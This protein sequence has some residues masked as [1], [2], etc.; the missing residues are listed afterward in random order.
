MEIHDETYHGDRP[1]ANADEDVLGFKD[2]AIAVADSMHALSS[3]DG[4]VVGIEGEWGAGKSSFINLVTNSMAERARGVE[5]VRFLPWLI[6][7]R[8]GMLDELF[9]EI[10]NAALRIVMP[11]P[12]PTRLGRLWQRISIPARIARRARARRIR[13]L[14]SN[15]SGRVLQTF[16]MVDIAYTG[17]M[18]GSAAQTGKTFVDAWVRA[19]SLASEKGELEQELR[20][21]D[22]KIMVLIDDLDR[23]EPGEVV[24]VLRLVRAVVDFPNVVFVLCYSREVVSKS[25]E[26]ALNVNSGDEF[27][28]KIIQVS[29]PVP[30]PE[31]FDLRRMLKGSIY[32][33]FD[34][35]LNGEDLATLEV[36]RRLDVVIDLEGGYGLS[37][38]RHVVRA[39][40]ALRFY[41]ASIVGCVDIAD[42]VWLQ[43]IR[44]QSHG[45]YMWV[46]HYLSEYAAMSRGARVDEGQ[47]VTDTQRL[48][49]LLEVMR[50][51]AG[52][53][54]TVARLRYLVEILP[55]VKYR[56]SSIGPTDGGEL[57]IYEAGS[58]WSGAQSRRLASP[59][60]YRYY[61]AFSAPQG[62]ITDYEFEDLIEIARRNKGGDSER[63]IKLARR[64]DPD[65]IP[66]A[67][68]LL[69]RIAASV[70]NMPED[71]VPGMLH[72]VADMMDECLDYSEEVNF[73]IDV[74]WLEGQQVFRKL[75]GRVASDARLVVVGEI[76]E[77]SPSIEWLTSTLRH[78]TYAH[79]IFGDRAE[80][81]SGWL[82]TAQE[83]ELAA[84]ALIERFRG[85]GDVDVRDVDRLLPVLY[86][87][88]QHDPEGIDEVKG[89]LRE[90]CRN[91]D[92]FISVLDRMRGWRSVNGVVSYPIY[93]EHV[94][95]FLDLEEVKNRLNRLSSS[96]LESDATRLLKSF[97]REEDE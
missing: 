85:M 50:K 91:D 10:L 51:D 59:H 57:K 46:E 64:T 66:A 1:I 92:G 63:M 54:A 38:P 30:R 77:K 93:E 18:A 36:R 37:T 70:E 56:L 21:L 82:L 86:A 4:F 3:P 65:G 16:K 44:L 87:W 76:F 7:S 73:G 49:S 8:D 72:A 11:A 69:R 12:A 97:A 26:A 32:K 14:Y 22:R 15:F 27:L 33:S 96:R 25:L 48:Q 81:V 45:L 17:G 80:D 13:K 39:V 6:S 74:M 71:A 41:G 55:G 90:W 52:P 78:E 75:L 2:A 83:Y 79:G 95:R 20:R 42:L 68:M 89:K 84:A 94:E 60:H 31:A 43:L 67:K 34:S 23:L 35:I 62:A 47:R 9:S 29:Y 88:I 61:F 24:E 19:P 58:G 40:N 53:A 28:G 5:L